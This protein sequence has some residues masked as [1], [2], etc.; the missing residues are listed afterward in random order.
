MVKILY[1]IIF[2]FYSFNET[3]T[4][5]EEPL[6]CW[7]SYVGQQLYK[8]TL[9]DLLIMIIS[10]FFVN[11][12]RKMIGHKLLRGSRLGTIVGEI[13]FEIPKHVLDIVYG[14]TLCWLGMFYSP[15]LP[16]VTC[17]K[18]GNFIVYFLFWNIQICNFWN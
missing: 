13:E 4:Q 11:F 8:L 2:Y 3:E 15:L 17:V 10:T 1:F 5:C 6:L 7:E 18:I 12:P 14:Q 16:A 9:L